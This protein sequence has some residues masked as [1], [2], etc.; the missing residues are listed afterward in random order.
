MHL[1]SCDLKGSCFPLTDYR[2][3]GINFPFLK[4]R[5]KVFF[6]FLSDKWKD[7]EPWI[8]HCA[9]HN[10]KLKQLRDLKQL[11]RSFKFQ[12]LAHFDRKKSIML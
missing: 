12:S 8:N 3:F 2:G 5:L 9:S 10:L 4:F 11:F 1:V 6:L 7:P